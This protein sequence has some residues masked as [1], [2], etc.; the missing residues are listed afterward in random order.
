MANSVS[1]SVYS[2]GFSIDNAVFLFYNF[3]FEGTPLF[4][5]PQF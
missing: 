1:I 3:L 4:S 2:Q 5:Q